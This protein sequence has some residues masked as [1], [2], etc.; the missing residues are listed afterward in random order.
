MSTIT[1]IEP[2]KLKGTLVFRA[3]DPGLPLGSR[4]DGFDGWEPKQQQQ[5]RTEQYQPVLDWLTSLGLELVSA[6]AMFKDADG[7]FLLAVTQLCADDSGEPYIDF[8]SD[9]AATT[10]RVLDLGVDATWPELFDLDWYRRDAGKW[11]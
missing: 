7:R 9:R 2:W 6:V 11:Y 3:P 8:A 5:W 1:E 10:Y 4:P